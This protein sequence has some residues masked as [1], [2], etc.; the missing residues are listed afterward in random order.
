MFEI[1]S[2]GGGGLLFQVLNSVAM[3]FGSGNYIFTMKMVAMMA[4][5]GITVQAAFTGRIPDIKWIIV[6]I[7]IYVFAFVPKVDVTITDTVERT[8][9]FPGSTPTVRVVGNVPIGLAFVASITSGLKDYFTRG[10]ETVFALPN[11]INYRQGGPLFAQGIAEKSLEVAPQDPNLNVSLANFWKDCVFY[12]IALGFYSMSDLAKADDLQN[13]LATNASSTRM[14]EH[15]SAS[16]T[17][18]FE[19]CADSIQAGALAVD[20]DA[21]LQQGEKWVGW[22][23]NY[24]SKPS[25]ATNNA[26]LSSTASAMPMAM[27]YLTGMS[28]TSSQMLGQATLANSFSKGLVAFASQAEAQEVMQGYAAAKAEAERNISFSTIGRIS[29]RMLPLINIIAEALIY[30]VFPII[31]LFML[32]PGG[33]KAAAAYAMALLWIALWAPL[34]AILHFFMMYFTSISA[35][36]AAQMCDA[37]NNCAPHL[38]MYTMH[39]LKD[40]FSSAA[41]I[42]GFMA[43]MVPYV[44]YML[45]SR[46][47]AMMAGTVGRL[48]DGYAAPAGHA[49]MEAAGGNVSVGTMSY[50]NQA[51]YQHNSA[52]TQTS[53]HMTSNDG[54]FKITESQLGSTVNQNMSSTAADATFTQ[55]AQS[56]T[57]Q[58]LETA[59]TRLSSA[60]SALAEAR[61]AEWR[62]S[63][64]HGESGQATLSSGGRTNQSASV[65]ESDGIESVQSRA[66]EY[67]EKQGW[68]ERDTKA[69]QAQLDAK[70]GLGGNAGA[71]SGG[72]GVGVGAGATYTHSKEETEAVDRVDRFLASDSGKHAL[73]SGREAGYQSYSDRSQTSTST[74]SHDKSATASAVTKAEKAYQTA[75]QEMESAKMAQQY[76]Q[77]QGSQL[78]IKESNAIAE[79]VMQEGGNWQ[80]GLDDLSKGHETDDARRVGNAIYSYYQER[81]QQAN[82]DVNASAEA[83][84]SQGEAERDANVTAGNHDVAADQRHDRAKVGQE[85]LQAKAEGAQGGMEKANMTRY[86]EEWQTLD[87]KRDMRNQFN[88]EAEKKAAQ[89]LEDKE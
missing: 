76:V 33:H 4:T 55:A 77:S 81:Q 21:E 23:N 13:F 15:V 62:E 59:T 41:A 27:Q 26:L 43:T 38:N 17:K 61:A 45:V 50:E 54:S 73:Q 79:R 60:T 28:L 6:I 89:R 65:R 70:L 1:V 58:A 14:Y 24:A 32:W 40:A 88:D 66:R 20:L 9:G 37:L 53:G 85:G 19:V 82:F 42:S 35:S 12:D 74:D 52:P 36:S 30:A 49:A 84:R 7:F 18:S 47:G 86:Q 80:K 78:S 31:A 68:S 72:V 34:Y 39:S 48:M 10:I 2:Y 63:H 57:S 25:G 29:G 67:A 11:E 51:A 8:P 5:I 22:V 87:D 71:V 69:F 56:S 16:G 83:I 64:S 3:F 44:A 75:L 46:S